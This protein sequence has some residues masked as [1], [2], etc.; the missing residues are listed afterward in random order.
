MRN[1]EAVTQ[2]ESPTGPGEM[3]KHRRYQQSYTYARLVACGP[4]LHVFG[5]RSLTYIGRR[6]SLRSS[7]VSALQPASLLQKLRTNDALQIYEVRSVCINAIV[8]FTW[9]LTLPWAAP[10]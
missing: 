5:R 8:R 1:N 2:E 9:Q 6:R 4:Y 3:G 10:R 7:L